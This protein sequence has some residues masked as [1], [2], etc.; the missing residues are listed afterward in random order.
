MTYVTGPETDDPLGAETPTGVGVPFAAGFAAAVM[1]ALAVSAVALNRTGVAARSAPATRPTAVVVDDSRALLAAWNKAGIH[2][3]V[4]VDVTRDT[5]YGPSA[6][7]G[8]QQQLSG[9]PVPM[10]DHQRLFREGV[11]RQSLVWVAA[12]TGVARS[13]A[14]VMN[15]FD[16]AEKLRAGRQAGL[17]GIAPDGRSVTA[18]DNGYLRWLGDRFPAVVANDAVLNIDASYFMNGTPEDLMRQLAR[19]R[20]PY[21]LVT[22]DRATDAAG[23]SQAAR[24]RLGRMAE[25]LRG[26]ELP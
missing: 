11:N 4:L 7:V 13:V 12:A 1:L 2:G 14:Y 22:L 19:S 3:V 8:P 25:M 21:R 9:W 18:N 6:A 5:E 20:V 26:R 24:A 23:V 10:I 16:F 17:S 15:P